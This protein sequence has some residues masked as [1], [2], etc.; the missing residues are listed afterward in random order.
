MEDFEESGPE[1]E[2]PERD[3]DFGGGGRVGR[4]GEMVEKGVQCL[5]ICFFMIEGSFE[6]DLIVFKG[7]N[8]IKMDI[9]VSSTIWKPRF[10][11]ISH[12]GLKNID[13]GA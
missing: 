13:F 4:K 9:S 10:C 2:I 6:A 12:P 11:Y 5:N 7:F 1:N 8:V 3:L